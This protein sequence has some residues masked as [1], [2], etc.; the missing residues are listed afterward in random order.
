MSSIHPVSV[1]LFLLIHIGPITQSIA[2]PATISGSHLHRA[3]SRFSL[4][5]SQWASSGDDSDSSEAAGSNASK[6]VSDASSSGSEAGSARA[7]AEGL[8]NLQLKKDHRIRPCYVTPGGTILLEV[9]IVHIPNS[10]LK[11]FSP[12]FQIAHEFLSTCAG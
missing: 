4:G 9:L 1:L 8:E 3:I 2:F 7:A 12:L 6:D 10:C 5:M 11:T